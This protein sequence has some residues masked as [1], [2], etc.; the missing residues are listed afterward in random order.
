M[1]DWTEIADGVWHARYQPI[2]IS[3][4][5]VRGADGLLLVDTRCNPREAAELAADVEAL[6]M[7]P[8]RWVV[9][10]H[11]HY[12]HSFGN[13]IFADTATIH[14]HHRIPAH[15]RDFEQPRLSAWTADPA[16]QPQYDWADVELTPPHVLLD[17]TI[18][19]NLG[20]RT[21]RLIPLPPGHTDTDLVVHVPDA[22]CW[23]VGDIVEESG[24]PMFGSGSFPFTW[25]RVIRDLAGQLGANDL[26]I[27]GHGKP[28]DRQF[29]LRQA[30]ELGAV[31][32]AIT[33]AHAQRL[34]AAAATTR[35]AAESGLPEEIVAPAVRRGYEQLPAATP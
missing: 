19:L 15:F 4:V 16:A 14:G 1:T 13:Q 17:E 7:G 20:G 23:I 35:I 24:P 5:F 26:V 30:A 25:P 28:V 27:P 10:T 21:V 11:A 22:A 32:D 33:E 12:D 34:D 6:N 31:A 29:M 9:N 2:D 18:E 8:I 3:T